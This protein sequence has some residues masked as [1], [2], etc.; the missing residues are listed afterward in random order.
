MDELAA[1]EEWV[2][3]GDRSWESFFH[4]WTAKEA[5]LKANGVGIGKFAGCRLVCVPD[6]LHMELVYD[7]DLW[8]VEHYHHADHI[9]A[10]TA[11][12][13]AIE[14]ALT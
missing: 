10:V 6:D 3:I 4:L 5:T 9:V 11:V 14:W 2:M 7:D 8:H 13:A 12:G 1:E